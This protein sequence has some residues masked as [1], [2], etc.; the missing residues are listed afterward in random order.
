MTCSRLAARLSRKIFTQSAGF[1]EMPINADAI[2]YPRIHKYPVTR[3][4]QFHEVIV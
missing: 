2:T 1:K 4:K 3:A